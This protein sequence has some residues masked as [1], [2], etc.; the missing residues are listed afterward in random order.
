VSVYTITQ[1]RKKKNNT[2]KKENN[3]GKKEYST[4]KK[5]YNIVYK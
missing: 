2:G 3:T 1:E 4:G 5:E